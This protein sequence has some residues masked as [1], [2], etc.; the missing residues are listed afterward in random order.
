MSCVW[1]GDVCLGVCTCV[2]MPDID[3]GCVPQSLPHLIFE[4]GFVLKLELIDWLD[5]LASELQGYSC[6]CLPCAG[7]IGDYSL[8][9][10]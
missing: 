6:L 1:Y 3:I 10:L 9:W 5:E 4:M 7:I 2:W 8:G